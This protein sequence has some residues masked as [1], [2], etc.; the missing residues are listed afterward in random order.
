MANTQESFELLKA[1]LAMAVVDGK[2][3]GHEKSLLKALAQRAG[4]GAVSLAAMIEQA[5]E[6]PASHDELFGRAVKDS[7]RAMQLL[8]A[9]AHIDGHISEQE[10]SLLVDISFVLGVSA[11]RFNSIFQAG[12]AASKRVRRSR[13]R[14]GGSESS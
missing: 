4:V 1:A 12:L 7:E 2:I 3:S 5:Q 13:T 9:A 8:V 6:N 11:E 14:P 10:R